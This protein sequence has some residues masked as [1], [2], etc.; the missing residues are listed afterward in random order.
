[1]NEKQI[2]ILG[3][4]V[5]LLTRQEVFHRMQQW[6]SSGRGSHHIVT[7]NPEIALL[8]EREDG[9]HKT[10][11]RADITVADGVGLQLAARIFGLDVPERITGRDILAFLCESA[12]KAGKRV[13]L[14]GGG[15]GVA[16]A[17]AGRLQVLY[18]GLIVA[19]AEEG[20]RAGQFSVDGPEA[21]ALADR[22]TAAQAEILFVAFGAPKQERW[23][24]KNL[25]RLPAVRVAVGIGGLFDYLAGEKPEPALFWQRHGL[26]WAYRLG[27]QPWRIRRIFNATFLFLGRVLLWKFRM[28][29]IM[30]KNVVACIIDRTHT[31]AL[32]VTPWW[33]HEARWQF[34]QGGVDRGESPQ[35]AVFRE[36]GEELG[37]QS[38]RVL[39]HLPKAHRYTWPRWYQFVKGYKG[40]DQ[41]LFILEFTGK[42]NELNLHASEELSQ[43][44]WVPRENILEEL[45]PRRRDVGAVAVNVLSTLRSL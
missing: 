3:A 45:A 30:R 13:Y 6:L 11:N 5:D 26:E 25:K 2:H 1:M 37:T 44:K 39:F 18:P 12:A 24:S 15:P 22:V 23:I 31:R 41:D 35:Q 33:S 42:D 32:V 38:F 27:T 4:K 9:F 21:K 14:A 17:A 16:Q 7:L 34:P 43:W 29:F 10:I 19:G 20:M 28:R 8:A 36:M 40:Q